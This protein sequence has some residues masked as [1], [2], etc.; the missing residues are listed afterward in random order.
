M[1]V[2]EKLNKLLS[3]PEQI[4]ELIKLIGSHPKDVEEVLNSKDTA[5]EFAGTLHHIAEGQLDVAP[6]VSGKVGVDGVA[7]A[8]DDL[9]HPEKH[10]KI[11]VE[12][13]R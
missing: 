9:A 1:S 13:W 3:S 7:Q 12:P 11:L 4:E 10:S 8:F 6:L 2:T 5:E